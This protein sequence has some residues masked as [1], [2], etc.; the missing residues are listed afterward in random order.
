MFENFPEYGMVWNLWGLACKCKNTFVWCEN[1]CMLISHTHSSLLFVYQF[2][3]FLQSLFIYAMC[4][5]FPLPFF[6]RRVV[7]RHPELFE[8]FIVMNCPHGRLERHLE[9]LT[10]AATKSC[11]QGCVVLGWG[12]K[13]AVIYLLL[14]F[15]LAQPILLI[16][17]LWKSPV[18]DNT[19]GREFSRL[20]IFVVLWFNVLRYSFDKELYKLDEMSLQ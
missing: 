3:S 13:L 8:K 4:L 15:L 19:V 14:Q 7:Y 6:C 12:L 9:C 1:T 11:S 17:T 5:K 2:S 20:K 18:C 10:V 16:S